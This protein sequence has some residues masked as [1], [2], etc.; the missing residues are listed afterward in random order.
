MVSFIHLLLY[1]QRKSPWFSLHRRLDG[2]QSLSGHC[3]KER[4]LALSG[5]EIRPSSL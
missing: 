3:G 5:I 4:N 2:A 1:L